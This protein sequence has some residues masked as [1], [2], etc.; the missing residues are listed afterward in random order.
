[1]GIDLTWMDARGAELDSV[2]DLESHFAAVVDR[3][4]Q[5]TTM[6]FPM[7]R[8]IDPY[9]TSRFA[10]PQVTTLLRELEAIRSH[11]TDPAVSIT[12]GRYLS[13]VRAAEGSPGTWLEF[14]G[15]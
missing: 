5:D 13:I 8:T 12:L 9:G 4:S 15:D 7:I 6:P 1:M 11:T 14:I 10:P 2:G 3:I